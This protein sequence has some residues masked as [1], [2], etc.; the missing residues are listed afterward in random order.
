MMVQLLYM[1]TGYC[2]VLVVRSLHDAS[3]IS[4]TRLFLNSVGWTVDDDEL[5]RD[6]L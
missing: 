2:L 4:A 6:V 3:S 5:V 1:F